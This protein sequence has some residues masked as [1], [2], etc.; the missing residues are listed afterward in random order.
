MNRF[1]RSILLTLS[2]LL[3]QAFV[4][5]RLYWVGGSGNFND[6][7]HWSLQSGGVGGVKTPTANDDVY[8]DENSFIDK[9]II[10]FIGATEVHDFIFTKYTPAIVFLGLQN[11]KITIHGNIHLNSYI[12]NQFAGDIWLTSNEASTSVNFEVTKFKGNIYFNGNTNWQIPGDVTTTDNVGVYFKQGNFNLNHAAIYSGN[13]AADPQVTINSNQTSFRITNKFVLPTGVVFNDTKSSI[14]AYTKDASKFQIAPSIVFNANSRLHN[15]NNVMSCNITQTGYTPPTCAGA[16]NATLTFNIPAACSGSSNPVYAVWTNGGLGCSLPDTAI[17]I[18]GSTYTVGNIC[19]CGQSYQVQFTNNPHTQDSTY[20]ITGPQVLVGNQFSITDPNPPQIQGTSAV[21]PPSC[22]GLCNGMVSMTIKIGTGTPPLQATWTLP[23]GPP[24]VVHSGLK[25][26]TGYNKDTLKNACAGTYSVF[27]A[28]KNGCTSATSTIALTQPALVTHTITPTEVLCNGACTGSIAE[29]MSGGTNPFTFTWTAVGGTVSSTA[30]SSTYSN[31]CAGTYT[32][33]TKDSH[34]CKD[35][36]VINITQPP[37]ITFTKNPASGTLI[38]PCISACNGNVG[39]TSVAGGTGAYA[40]S[41]LPASGTPTNGVNSSVYSGLCGSV[42]GLTYTCTITDANSCTK[43]ASFTVKAPPALSHTISATNPKCN[44]GA[45]GCATVTESGGLAP[46][47]FSWSPAGTVGG[48]SPTST[49]CN[50]GSGTYTVVATDFNNCTDT[51]TITLIPPPVL[52]AA[53]S[54]PTNPTCPAL[55]NGKL[56]VT[57]GGGTPVYTYAWAPASGGT[58][59]CTPATMVSGVYTVTVTDANSCTVTTSAALVPPP[60]ITVTAAVTQPSCAG[61][62]NGSATLTAT[63]GGGGFVYHWSCT[64]TTTSVI[65]GQAGGTTCN[66]TVTDAN[67]CVQ[68]GSVSFTYP[69]P[70]TL[71]LTPT[72]LACSGNCNAQITTGVGGGTPTYAYA[73]SGSNPVCGGCPNQTNMCAGTYTCTITDAHGCTKTANT[74]ITAPTPITV[75]FTP[76][77]PTCAGSCNGSI[78]AAISGGTGAPYTTSWSPAL[79]APNAPTTTHPINLCANTY[80]LQVT[81]NNAC[82]VTDTV[83]LIDPTPVTI[84]LTTTS[85]TCAGQNNG[86][87][88]VTASGGTPGYQYSWDNGAFGGVTSQSNLTPG[89]HTIVV[90]DS[91]GCLAATQIFTINQPTNLVVNVINIIN[92]CNGLCN[93]GATATASGGT[94]GYQFSWDVAGGPFTSGAIS[95]SGLCAGS[96]TLFAK[97][98]NN[99]VTSATFTITPVINISISSSSTS[100]SCH[101]LCDGTATAMASGSNSP[102]YTIQWTGPS[103]SST[104]TNVPA[105][106]PCTGT[107]LCGT[108]TVTATD[109]NGC[110]NTA[111]LSIANPPALA[112]TTNTTLVECFGLCT[113]TATVTPSGGTPAASA[114][115]YS[116][117]WSPAPL[118]N[119]MTQSNLCPGSYTASIIDN[120]GCKLIQP[121]V[122]GV[123]NQFSVNPTI[124]APSTCGASDAS[125]ALAISGGSGTY[126]VNW[127]P[128]GSTANPLTGIPAGSYTATIKDGN[129]CDTVIAYSVN[130][131]TGP[132]TTVTINNNITCFG[133]CNG[134]ATVSGSGNGVITIAWPGANPTGPSPQTGT[135]LCGNPT[136]YIVKATDATGCVTNTTVTIVSPGI[137]KDHSNVVQ[138]SCT[139]ALGSITLAPSG[140]NGAPYSYS[141]NSGPFVV[142]NNSLTGLSAGVYTCV[143][144]D[145][146]GCM[147]ATFTYTMN[148]T[149]TPSVSV[150]TG[151]VTCSYSKNGTAIASTNGGLPAYTYTWTNWS[152]VVVAQGTNISNVSGLPPGTY[153]LSVNDA[154]NCNVQTTFTIAAPAVID[155]HFIKNNNSCN[156]GATGAATVAPTGGSGTY[157][158]NWNTP[159]NPT[160][161]TVSALIPGNYHVIIYDANSCSDTTNFTITAPSSLTIAVAFTNPTCFGVANGSATIT[162]VTGGTPYTAS[163]TPPYTLSWTGVGCPTCSVVTNLSGGTPYTAIATDSNGC[164]VS[165]AITLTQPGQI[166]PTFTINPPTCVGYSNGSILSGTVGIGGVTP[167]SYQW[168]PAGTAG[169]VPTANNLSAGTY[170]YIITD[171]NSCST[172]TVIPLNDPMALSLLYSST[173]AT[174]NQSNGS[175]IISSANGTGTVSVKWVNPASCATSYTCNALPAGIY[176]IK[177]TDS[178]G[179]TDT[180]LATVTN[181]GGPAVTTVTTNI[182]C[183]GTCNGAASVTVTSGSAPYTFTWNAPP[184]AAS[185]V[186]TTTTSIASGLCDSTYISIVADAIGCKTITSFSIS[187][188]TQ[189][190]DNPSITSATCFGINNGSITSNASGGKPFVSG[191]QYSIDGGA[192]SGPSVSHAFSNL[193]A[194]THTVS[195]TDSVGCMRNFTYTVTAAAVITSNIA[196]TNATC[197]GVCDGTATV[198]NIIGGTFPIHINWND[199]NNQVGNFATNLCAGSYTA[200]IT[201]NSGCKAF[202]TI[203][204]VAPSIINPN[205]VVINPACG[206]CNGK[207]TVVP[208][209]GSGAYTYTWTSPPSHGPSINNICAGPYQVTVS[210]TNGCAQ[211]FHILVSSINAATLTIASTNETCNS[212]CSGSATVTA[213]VGGTAPYTYSWPN[214]TPVSTSSVASALC[215]TLSPYFVQVKDSAGCI[216]TQSVAI[217]SPQS[218][219]VS[220]TNIAPSCTVCNGV[221]TTTVVGASTYSYQWSANAGSVTTTSVTGLCAGIYT[222][223]V[224]D[225]VSGCKQTK[226]ITLNNNAGPTLNITPTPI[227]C[228]GMCNGSATVTA[229]FGTTPYTYTWSPSGGNGTVASNLCDSTYF[230]QVT[231]AAN[232]IQIS[233]VD[234]TSPT[235]LV[236]S[237]PTVSPIKCANDCNGSINTVIFGGTP[238]YT[239]TWS[240]PAISGTGG[241]N[242]C[243]GNYSLTVTD[244]NGCSVQEFDTLV[245]P[246]LV[247]T[248][249]TVTPSSCNNIADGGITTLTSGGTPTYTY[250]WSGGSNA[251]TQSLSNILSGNYTLVTTDTKACTDTTRYN[252][253]SGITVLANAGRDTALCS[254]ASIVLTGTVTG[255][256]TFDWQDISGTIIP[257]ANTLTLS[258]N[259]ATTTQYVLMAFNGACIDKD[260]VTVSVS[261]VAVANA[262]ASQSVFVGQTATIGG[263]PSN[264]AGGIIVWMPNIGL[265]DTLSSNP[266]ASPSVTTTY[267]LLVTNALGC[268]ASDTMIVTILPPFNINNGFTPNGD[269]KN[270]TWVLDELYK[271][272]NT[273]IEIYNRWGEQLFYSKGAYTPWNGTYKGQPVPVGTYYYI[274]R[275]NDKNFPDHYA[276]P[277][278]ILR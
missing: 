78:N 57:A 212:L 164:S 274:I 98:S 178:N 40:F 86:T 11:E 175:V 267:T 146:L 49:N 220:N 151:S 51:A 30:N 89:T 16:C 190:H 219:T 169:N 50:I 160:T 68:T 12:D 253:L 10:S 269:G 177:L 109:V 45:T 271:F 99:C 63:G 139:G 69:S 35:S 249:G 5:Q 264:P 159:G 77:N 235:K 227:T 130:N 207:I 209:G 244:A 80:S 174:C 243:S 52:T 121:V 183:Y 39:V 94:P 210:D 206:Q 124:T 245:N 92:T 95:V 156:T 200:T 257:P 196:A 179:C 166:S 19:G 108:V 97:D 120:N 32:V 1:L 187:K 15:L 24:T 127:A 4:A 197:F 148:T 273:E 123:S 143:I 61:L 58:L 111:T 204:I 150:S 18:P 22:F 20:N 29:T 100:V 106:S 122:I 8:F 113:G 14:F 64:A 205:T 135:N 161:P 129:G 188:P 84:S 48:S 275:L 79:P 214:T 44:V 9:S 38:I 217:T 192:I 85:I 194:G 13:L 251:Q 93:G 254:N 105:S 222:L 237:L 88:S 82:T 263:N 117:T 167:Y 91:R 268:V 149:N 162:A 87:A 81:D 152:N 23:S 73:W 184:T 33:R 25:N 255:T 144:E 75:T 231:D 261:P 104:C 232:C 258:V 42:A 107:N 142:G 278:T 102:P 224:T 181:S 157:T 189:L 193:T 198:S 246:T 241:T 203:S 225:N 256:A 155:P 233:Q 17:L 147:S 185:V 140:G 72:T 145:A 27:I 90:K 223:V 43:T 265:S 56:C 176:S 201:D 262:G 215:A 28:D 195:I 65:T 132:T 37:V 60:S 208:S 260:T 165:K 234:I 154:N 247:V 216:T 191:Y 126:T 47:T 173:P 125:I 236:I 168:L 31:L 59:S 34:L 230:V 101:N 116:I 54:T 276:G 2:L 202:D 211:V 266:I 6:P 163:G 67:N 7:K 83:S 248:T 153:S 213:V 66:Y 182:N 158:V 180:L 250:Q 218:F 272:P 115:F 229:T 186:S 74:A 53:I 112:A 240:S 114:P 239:Y 259:P 26:I 36:A 172:T 70:L 103:S 242:L 96:H 270:D 136:N 141:W 3:T 21:L 137:I 170:T 131:L 228:F 128:G 110:A 171:A 41:W 55:N 134:S 119:G 238:S 133:I 226:V 62:P 46:Y 252:V 277:L 71:T 221:I 138:P 199:P 76:V 118:P